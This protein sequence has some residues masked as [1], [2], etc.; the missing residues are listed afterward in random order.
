MEF[1]DKSDGLVEEIIDLFASTFTASEGADEGAVIGTLVSNLLGSTA[2]KDIFVFTALEN[3]RVIGGAIFSRLT[4]ADDP[5][6]VFILSPMAVMTKMQ[7]KGVGQALLTNALSA[8]RDNAVEVALTYGAPRFYAKV[9]FRPLDEAAAA[10]PL[11]L[12]F[13]EGWVG[14]SLTDEPLHPLQGN[15]TCVTALNDPAIW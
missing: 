15:S 10:P 3:G 14:Q 5:R 12:S 13:P 8:L 2:E 4:F 7:G 1:H 6:S 11:P 9:G